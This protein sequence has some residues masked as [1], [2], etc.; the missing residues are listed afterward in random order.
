M[1]AQSVFDRQEN[2]TQLFEV[3]ED[4][5]VYHLRLILGTHP[6]QEL[7]LGLGNAQLVEGVLDIGGNVI[8][9]AG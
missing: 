8:P 1:F 7:A 2:N 4:G 3:L 5:V 9:V 6:C